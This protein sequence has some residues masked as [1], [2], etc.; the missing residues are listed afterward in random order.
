MARV[1][2]V[3]QLPPRP[4]GQA[5]GSSTA[6]STRAHHYL[7]G[8]L[9]GTDVADHIS[10]CQVERSAVA[11]GLGGTHLHVTRFDDLESGFPEEVFQF[12]ID[13]HAR[14]QAERELS[15]DAP[16]CCA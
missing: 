11:E 2:E 10:G 7:T 16:I 13:S 1:Q 3:L 14:R 15:L 4:P 12:G 5:S 8:T 6:P 9:N